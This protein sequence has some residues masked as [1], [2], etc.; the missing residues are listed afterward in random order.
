MA[1]DFGKLKARLSEVEA[2]LVSEYAA[3]RTGQATPA[4]LDSIEIDVYGA[5]DKISHVASIGIEDPK[6]LR[7]TPWDKGNIAAIE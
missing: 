3:V 5:K 4:L 2:W 1:Y 7:I 6:T